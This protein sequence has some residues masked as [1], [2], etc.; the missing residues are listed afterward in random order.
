MFGEKKGKEKLH[1]YS[2]KSIR[3]DKNKNN[4]QRGQNNHLT[5]IFVSEKVQKQ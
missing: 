2:T 1:N 3:I 4:L 5:F